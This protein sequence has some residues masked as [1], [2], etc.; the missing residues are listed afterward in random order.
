MS[1]DQNG[2]FAKNIFLPK[3]WKKNDFE[4]L[5]GNGSDSALAKIVAD[6]FTTSLKPPSEQTFKHTRSI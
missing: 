1:T 2:F 4:Y 3:T 5:Y 6:F